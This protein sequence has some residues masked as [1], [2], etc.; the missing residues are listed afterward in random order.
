[1]FKRN[2]NIFTQ[3]AP[4]LTGKPRVDFNK[5]DFEALIE[6]KGYDVFI[7]KA[8][9][10]PC[11]SKDTGTQPLSSCKNCGGSG[12]AF[13]N[14]IDTRLV[15]HSMNLET[16]F[17]EW[18]KE[19]LGTVSVTGRDIEDLGYMDRITVVD[20]ISVF[21]QVVYPFIYD[22]SGTD[23][24]TAFTIYD[25]KEIEDIFLFVSSSAK[26]QRLALTTDYTFE[27]N[28]IIFNSSF[29][30]LT[31]PQMTVRY[32]HSPQFHII[33]FPRETMNT[34]VTV[35]GK[36]QSVRM[37]IH[38][39]ARRSHYVLDAENFVGDRVLDNSYLVDTDC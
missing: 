39:V 27:Y 31:N 1:M 25:I 13:I 36:E 38:A 14:K 5:G 22:D 3:P 9:R 35:G 10:C 4:D 26:Y 6:Q 19:N 12:Y 23:R 32:K 11:G 20:A 15:L 28:K 17:R 18:S 7:E 8:F 2:K 16:K 37:P 29:N 33:D 21:N 24:L 34:F 30:S